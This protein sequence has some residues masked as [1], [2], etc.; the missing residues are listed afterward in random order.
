MIMFGALVPVETTKLTS[1]GP[2]FRKAIE[3]GANR[4]IGTN[5]TY[6]NTDFESMM[7]V[8]LARSEQVNPLPTTKE[9]GA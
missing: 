2:S 6:W 3:S 8:Q 1:P 5:E 7:D 9:F 4:I